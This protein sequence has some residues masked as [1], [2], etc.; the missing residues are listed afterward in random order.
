MHETRM[1]VSGFKFQVSGLEQV[2]ETRNLKLETI[3]YMV[4]V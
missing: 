4:P 1:T 2:L 3:I